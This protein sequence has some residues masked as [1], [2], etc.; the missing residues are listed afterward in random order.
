MNANYND[1]TLTVR[2]LL[3]K[4]GYDVSGEGEYITTTTDGAGNVWELTDNLYGTLDA[5]TSMEPDGFV[6]LLEC[7]R[8]R[9]ANKKTFAD[10][11]GV[12]WSWCDMCG[13]TVGQHFRFC[14]WCGAKFVG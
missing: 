10:D 14:P 13:R 1:A 6:A 12:G 4:A 7:M 2:G 11:D 9:V 8:T 5:H 3:S